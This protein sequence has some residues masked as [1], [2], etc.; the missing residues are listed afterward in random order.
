MKLQTANR[1]ICK[2]YTDNPTVDFE[3][4]N[5]I[6]IDL[7]EKLLNDM[8]S[9]MNS[10]IHSQI[11]SNVNEHSQILNEIKTGFTSLKNSVSTLNTDITNSILIKFMD[12]KKEYI[13]DVKTIVYNNTTDK[14]T[15]LLERN[16][17]YLIDKTTL[18]MNDII[19]KSQEHYYKQIHEN[20][21]SFHKSISSDTI[22]LI[23]YMENTSSKDHIKDF[24]TNFETKS[25]LMIQNVQQP[26]YNFISASEERIHSDISL[27]KEKTSIQQITQSKVL[28]EMSDFIHKYQVSHATPQSLEKNSLENLLNKTYSTAEISRVDGHFLMSRTKKPTIF[29]QN[30]TQTSNVLPDEIKGFVKN[31]SDQNCNGVFL[32]QY[33]GITSK[34]NYH[35]ET[36]SGNIMVYVHSVDYSADKIKIA[37]DIIDNLSSKLRELHSTD[38]DCAIPKDVL[39][40]INREYHAF[41]S[42]KDNISNTFKEF[43]KKTM[44]QLD[45]L[46]FPSLDKFLSTKYTAVHK[47]GFKCDLCKTFMVS[48]LKGLAAHKRGCTRKQAITNY[49]NINIDKKENRFITSSS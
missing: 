25:S 6:F 32:S 18:M 27:L 17:N 39:D 10:T 22:R 38:N 19:P 12:I 48:T 16:N 2:F 23:K 30:T 21:Q 20:I 14:V 33:T 15:T 37:V 44:L 34:P 13:E 3:A 9:T 45:D 42:Q 7:F 35:I 43:Q 5:L 26:I 46:K 40:E 11:L 31:V 24:I 4:V 28:E 41:I 36:Q 8:N 1:R 47:Q 29:I 49:V